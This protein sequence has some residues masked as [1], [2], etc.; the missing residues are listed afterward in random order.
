QQKQ[1]ADATKSASSNTSR[2][3]SSSG[4]TTPPRLSVLAKIAQR[5]VPISVKTEEPQP[6]S[7]TSPQQLRPLAQA[8]S[9]NARALQKQRQPATT[10]STATK[11]GSPPPPPRA[12]DTSVT[13]QSRQQGSASP[14]D[15][16]T[17]KR[18]ERL[19]KNRA[20]ALLSRKRKREYMTKLESE[21]EELRET[22]SSLAR[23]LEK[24]EQQLHLLAAER[25]MLRRTSGHTA[26]AAAATGSSGAA[27]TG[28]DSTSSGDAGSTSVD[29]ANASAEGEAPEGGSSG[30]QEDSHQQPQ[31]LASNAAAEGLFDGP[32]DS[33]EEDIASDSSAVSPAEVDT[34]D[35]ESQESDIDE[36][37]V[38][39]RVMPPADAPKANEQSGA[40]KQRSAG[41]LLMAMLFSFSLFTLPSLYAPGSQIAAGGSQS[42]GLLPTAAP[43]A[44]QPRLLISERGADDEYPLVE[45]VRRTISALAQG[46]D[47]GQ[48]AA[49]PPSGHNNTAGSRL[50][51]MTMEESA[52]LHSWI[53]RGLAS[54]PG[55]ALAAADASSA[56]EVARDR[57]RRLGGAAVPLPR[58]LDAGAACT[59]PQTSSLSVVPQHAPRAGQPSYAMLYCP[60]MKHVLF[61][62]DAHGVAE[63]G[64]GAERGQPQPAVARVLGEA[65]RSAAGAGG[66]ANDVDDIAYAGEESARGAW[67]SPMVERPAA[68][69]SLDVADLAPT[70]ADSRRAVHR[71][72]LSFYSPVAAGDGSGEG[73]EALPP[74]EEQARLSSSLS[75]SSSSSPLAGVGS[76]MSGT[77]YD[78]KQKYL[79]I[80]VEVVGSKWVTAD[81]FASGLMY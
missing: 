40:S 68:D 4:N 1:G 80:D 72:K 77:G 55:P 73:P 24:M 15:C 36:P 2:S 45:R 16:V 56:N 46:A 25:D 42:A 58:E 57:V 49:P 78:G 19:I 41:V 51:P 48:A 28:A 50:R 21:V 76:R 81:K 22:N 44:T 59:E 63:M 9:P 18:Q 67:S 38:Q 37:G 14:A 30:D 20:A 75:S 79:R 7:S 32:P 5:Q 52:N 17:Q 11:A 70:H 31:S 6:G 66:S 35:E 10:L 54:G 39:V 13:P 8:H 69:A 33:M 12:M 65:K 53:R 23:R 47:D 71:P 43:P 74:W 60:T 26:S 3:T 27:A 61:G 29:N 62:G 64:G 34:G